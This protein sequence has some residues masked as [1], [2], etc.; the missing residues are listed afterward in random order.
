MSARLNAR[1]S[2][3]KAAGGVGAAA[4]ATGVTDEIVTRMGGRQ[5]RT[6][7]DEG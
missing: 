2:L 3:L 6:W 7:V 1:S 5:R 4:V